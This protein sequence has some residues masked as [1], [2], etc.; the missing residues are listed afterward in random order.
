[1]GRHRVVRQHVQMLQALLGDGSHFC[2]ALLLLVVLL[3]VRL[4]WRLRLVGWSFLLLLV[5]DLP[6]DG[7]V[8]RVALP[9]LG[10]LVALFVLVGARDLAEVAA[11]LTDNPHVDRG[12]VCIVLDLRHFQ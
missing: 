6:V 12:C 7:D 11:D 3:V 10:L 9:R 4:V 2:A 8:A 1:M 5:A